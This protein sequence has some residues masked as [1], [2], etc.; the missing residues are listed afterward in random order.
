MSGLGGLRDGALGL[1][2]SHNLS[3]LLDLDAPDLDAPALDTLD[4]VDALLRL[5]ILDGVDALLRLE[6][7][8][9]EPSEGRLAA[10]YG[11][12]RPEGG[13]LAPATPATPPGGCFAA[14]TQSLILGPLLGAS[15]KSIL[16]TG[17][18][19]ELGSGVVLVPV[20]AVSLSAPGTGLSTR[21]ATLP[22][23]FWHN[24]QS[25]L[26]FLALDRE[27]STR[28]T[29]PAFNSRAV[30]PERVKGGRNDKDGNG[31]DLP[32]QEWECRESRATRPPCRRQRRR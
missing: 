26:P 30:T 24:H 22:P 23:D 2:I 7:E 17:L 10:S 32:E 29:S 6:A 15:G 21:S 3:A 1:G 5:G 19:L 12:K 13:I 9:P 14:S 8:P 11:V 18:L 28:S 4:G 27:N 16:F 31:P 20:F 25:T